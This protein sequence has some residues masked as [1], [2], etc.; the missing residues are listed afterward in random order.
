MPVP[1][2]VTT[3]EAPVE[4]LLAMVSEPETAP[5][6]VGLNCTLR[7]TDWF[8]FKVSGKVAPE[9]VKPVPPAVTELMVK[10][11]E[12]VEERVT[13]CVAG[14]FRLTLPKAM[15]VAFTLRVGTA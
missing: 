10:A 3:A 5:A 7:V 1:V 9:T 8:G 14:E 15:V 12:P 13:D 4:E 11:A 6:A 2:R